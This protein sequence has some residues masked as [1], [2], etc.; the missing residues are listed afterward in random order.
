MRGLRKLLGLMA[1]L[2]GLETIL[3]QVAKGQLSTTD[4]AEQIRN[5]ASRPHIPR[6]FPRVFR[7]M[8]ATFAIVG[9]GFGCYSIVFG[10]G[11]KE[12][13]GTVTEILDG[14]PVVEYEVNGKAFSFQ[15]SL[16]STPPMYSTG[17]KVSVL[18]R[19]NNP[20]WAQ[21]NSFTDRWLFPVVFTVAGLWTV[22]CSYQFPKWISFLTGTSEKSAGS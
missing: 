18:Y 2:V 6:W 4:A 13:Q 11:A 7:M 1:P 10:I 5:L 22:I 14:S 19:P 3:D 15:S 17:D 21:I 20:G 12:V 16:S 8:G 9:I